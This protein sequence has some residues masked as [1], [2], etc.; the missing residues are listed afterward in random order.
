MTAVNHPDHYQHPSGIECVDI[1]RHLPHALASAFEYVWRWRH[2]NGVE[3][4]RKAAWW[5]NDWIMHSHPYTMPG[6]CYVALKN[7]RDDPDYRTLYAILSGD[8][9][10]AL[11]L[12]QDAI[13]EAITDDR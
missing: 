3:D 4:L 1:S 9:C 7:L 13:G 10:Q 6:P 5:L 11:N 8:V 12:I 2:K